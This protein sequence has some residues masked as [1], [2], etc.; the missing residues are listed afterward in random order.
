MFCGHNLYRSLL[1]YNT[2][3]VISYFYFFT[4]KYNVNKLNITLR[5]IFKY[6][7]AEEEEEEQQEETF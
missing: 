5:G 1:Y 7:I 4:S 2:S 3:I 6:Y